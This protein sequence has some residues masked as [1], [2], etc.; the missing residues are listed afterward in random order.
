[1]VELILWKDQEMEKLKKDLDRLFNHRC[2]DYG[3]DFFCRELEEAPSVEIYETQEAITVTAVL[4]GILP[5]DLDISLAGRILTIAGKRREKNLEKTAYF[6]RIRKRFDAFSR[7]VELPCRVK[8]DEIEAKFEEGVLKIILP[9]RKVDT[10]KAVR[11][12]VK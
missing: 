3:L 12:E 7:S 4:P 2:L 6:Q 1:M 10:P 11:I 8:A 5:E 9:K